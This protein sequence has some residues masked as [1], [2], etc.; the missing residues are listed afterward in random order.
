MPAGPCLLNNSATT[1]VRVNPTPVVTFKTDSVMGCANFFIS[2]VLTAQVTPLPATYQWYM[3]GQPIAGATDS[4]LKIDQSGWYNII[5]VVNGCPSD[6]GVGKNVN[7]ALSP[8]GKH[9][10][11]KTMICHVPDCRYDKEVTICI[12]N[13]AVNDHLR[14]H[15]CDCLGHCPTMH[16]NKKRIGEE[17]YSG[18]HFHV[19]PNPFSRN[20][21]MDFYISD[22]AFT[23]LDI[24]DIKGAFI[25]RLFEDNAKE[26][27]EYR[28]NI[29]NLS[30]GV[31]FARL[32][33]GDFIKHQV[34]I[35]TK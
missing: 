22:A 25:S 31:Y 7:I 32:V 34:L 15:P 19:Y 24:Y 1:T 9:E 20:A 18:I 29:T 23:T 35:V 16:P 30:E 4:V 11:K 5:V 26:D 8:C 6:S 27:T 21:A 33:S 3:N 28:V 12:G 17:D 10:E 13:P 14:L 2:L